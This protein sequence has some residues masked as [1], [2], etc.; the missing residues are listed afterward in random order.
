M[1]GEKS[2]E[3]VTSGPCADR[4]YILVE[5]HACLSLIP[6]VLYPAEMPLSPVLAMAQ[7]P[8]QVS[9]SLVPPAQVD[10]TSCIPCFALLGNF[11]RSLLF[12]GILIHLFSQRHRNLLVVSDSSSR[13]Q[14]YLSPLTHV[15]CLG[16]S[17]HHP[18]G[19]PEL[20]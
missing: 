8:V 1:L 7:S 3:H 11:L 12:V 17:C 9:A 4:A 20:V 18:W 19:A 2:S 16:P 13:L 10:T 15:E 14:S 6:P 5:W